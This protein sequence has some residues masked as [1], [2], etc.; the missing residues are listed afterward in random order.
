MKRDFIAIG[1][2]FILI[3]TLGIPQL[4]FIGSLVFIGSTLIFVA[5]IVLLVWILTKIFSKGT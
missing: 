2:L 4:G 1:T 3:L 5:G